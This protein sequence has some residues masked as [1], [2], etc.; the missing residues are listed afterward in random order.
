MNN[1]NNNNNNINNKKEQKTHGFSRVLYFAAKLFSVLVLFIL[2]IGM[3]I[4]TVFFKRTTESN[5]DKNLAKLPEFSLKSFLYGKY[6]NDF[7]KYFSDTVHGRDRFKDYATQFTVLYGLTEEEEEFGSTE[8]PGFLDNSMPEVE[9]PIDESQSGSVPS[10]SSGSTS[11]PTG[12]TSRPS[13]ES[14]TAPVVGEEICDGKVILGT[15]AMEIFYGNEANAK[16]FAEY[17]NKY[18]QDL[19]GVN[20]YS[21][22]IPKPCAYYI[23]DSKKYGDIWKNTV[24]DLDAIKGTLNGV[25]YVDVYNALLPHKDEEIYFRTDIHWTGLGAYYAAKAFAESAGVPFADLST[26][27][28]NVRSGYVGTMY[29][30]T[31]SAK[32]LNNPEDF[33]TYKPSSP[34]TATFYDYKFQNGKKHDLFYYFSDDKKSSWYSTFL[35]GDAYSTKIE[36]GTCNNGRKVVIFKDSYGNPIAPY[37]LESFEEIY[38]IDIRKFELNA[39]DFIKDNGITDVVFAVSAFTASGSVSNNIERIRTK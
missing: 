14:T 33:V 1:N 34:Y 35:N 32:L 15:R 21:M 5:Y 36:S 17:L 10:D 37:L 13:D 19:N 4:F 6:T 25:K 31:Q 20:I 27:E 26:Y 11:T 39:V 12:E 23:Q 22:V 24:R 7:S 30:Y 16:M 9:I 3:F 29:N 8:D 2:I 18:A 38:V 28:K